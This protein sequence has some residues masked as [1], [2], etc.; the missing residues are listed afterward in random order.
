MEISLHVYQKGQNEHS[1][2]NASDNVE[3]Q[4]HSHCQWEYTI[5]CKSL[6]KTVWWFLTKLNGFLAYNSATAFLNIFSNELK[7]F[8][9]TRPY[10]N[11]YSSFVHKGKNLEAIKISF[12]GWTNTLWYIQIE[13]KKKMSC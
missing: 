11:I 4:K 7:T 3:Q 10:M 8:G 1:T 5:V 9:N 6:W 13:Q 2:S 12:S